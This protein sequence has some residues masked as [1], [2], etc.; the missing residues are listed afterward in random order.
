MVSMDQQFIK[1]QLKKQYADQLVRHNN[2]SINTV[3]G[4]N[5]LARVTN[6]RHLINMG[7]APTEVNLLKFEEEI[8]AYLF[9]K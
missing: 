4:W 6:S 5:D 8:N 9:A 2:L 3:E 7:I 1:E